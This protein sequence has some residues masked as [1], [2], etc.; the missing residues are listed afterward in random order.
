M[1]VL[2]IPDWLLVFSAYLT[3]QAFW[4][5]GVTSL[6][7]NLVYG[8]NYKSPCAFVVA[9]LTLTIAVFNSTAALALASGA[10]LAE[11]LIL[12]PLLGS[13]VLELPLLYLFLQCF[14]G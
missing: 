1:A 5:R 11:P 3:A 2:L 13:F 12:F 10:H 7:Y 4:Y 14:V 8:M 6:I 9:A